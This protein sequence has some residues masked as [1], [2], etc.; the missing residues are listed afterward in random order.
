MEQVELLNEERDLLQSLVG[1]AGWKTFV[2][3]MNG[4]KNSAYD[5]F[6]FEGDLADAKLWEFRSEIRTYEYVLAWVPRRIAE[7]ERELDR[8]AGEPEQ[9]LDMEPLGVSSFLQEFQL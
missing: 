7:I 6:M 2:Q 8:L 3:H 4:R 1:A 5:R 9:D